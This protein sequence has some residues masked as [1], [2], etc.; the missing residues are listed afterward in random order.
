MTRNRVEAAQEKKSV[1]CSCYSGYCRCDGCCTTSTT[2][3]PRLT[4]EPANEFFG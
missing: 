4:S 3:K 2:V 1:L